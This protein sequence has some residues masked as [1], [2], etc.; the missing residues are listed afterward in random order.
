MRILFTRMAL[1][2]ILLST[3]VSPNGLP[4]TS[5]REKILAIYKKTFE[6]PSDAPSFAALKETL[7]RDGNYYILEGDLQL[8]EQELRAYVDAKRQEGEKQLPISSELIVN[9]WN[10]QDDYYRKVSDRTLNYALDRSSFEGGADQYAVVARN[11]VAATK[12]WESSCPQC[13]IN[14]VY[15]PELDSN[16]SAT[17]LNFVVRL[18]DVHGAYIAASFFPHDDK[19]RRFLNID[20]SYFVAGFD[21]TG[22][23]R[24]ELGHVL[25]YRHEHIRG[26]P[27]CYSEG[28]QWRP[29]TEYDP[30]S[31]MHYFCG[32]HGSVALAL[33]DLDV[34]GH[35]QL[36][37]S[38]SGSN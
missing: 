24:H 15:K 27:G 5:Q 3:S 31:V 10:D 32:G 1:I 19:L 37:S 36:Y 25:G 12:A 30:K 9:R 4:Q 33:T 28:N 17:E 2:F 18:H 34:R 8:T 16:P 38:S 11:V 21:Q 23:L 35:R 14:F 26:I 13:Q 29:L 6:H 20:P 7:P 22:V